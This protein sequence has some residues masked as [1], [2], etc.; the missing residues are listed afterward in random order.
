MNSNR[1]KRYLFSYDHAGSSW[2]IELQAESE[3]DAKARM[4]KM[5]W[6]RFD[7]EIVCTLPA[8][9]GPFGRLASWVRNSI[10]IARSR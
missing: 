8:T 3:E 2:G 6:A 9:L 7:G 4:A 1:F 10:Q 5:C